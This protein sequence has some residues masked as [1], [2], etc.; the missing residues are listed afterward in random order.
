MSDFAI[1]AKIT[2]A[3]IDELLSELHASKDKQIT[4]YNFFYL[5]LLVR[6]LANVIIMEKE[7]Y[8]LFDR[9]K[10]LKL[11]RKFMEIL[12]KADSAI[13]QDPAQVQSFCLFVTHCFRLF[14]LALSIDRQALDGA[15]EEDAQPNL[16]QILRKYELY[17]K[18]FPQN[19]K[20]INALK[21]EILWFKHSNQGCHM[22]SIYKEPQQLKAQAC[23]N[24]GQHKADLKKCSR[25]M[26]V[27]YCD[28][29]C[30]KADYPKHKAVCAPA[31]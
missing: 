3:V 12:F 18:A 7:Q 8:K 5:Q 31:K 9:V 15:N 17:E 24:C 22:K 19:A 25:C 11:I 6:A 2:N 16:R 28:R 21:G 13:L 20:L 27:A 4:Q 30:Q 14:I 10:N 1:D 23:G 29:D 26:K